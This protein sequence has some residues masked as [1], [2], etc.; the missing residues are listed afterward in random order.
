MILTDV[1]NKDME[2]T[3][4]WFESFIR[5]IGNGIDAILD[6]APDVVI[7]GIVAAIVVIF[8]IRLAKGS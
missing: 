1:S 2:D 3:L 5:T 7:G 6:L 4:N 8:L